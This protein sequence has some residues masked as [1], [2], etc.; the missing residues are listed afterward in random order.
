[1]RAVFREDREID[2]VGSYLPQ[3]GTFVEVGAYH[4]FDH[5]QTWHL[6]QRGWNGALIEPVPEYAERLRQNRS[7]HVFEAACGPPHRHGTQ[8]T[9]YVCGLL[10]SLKHD[11]G[12]SPQIEVRIL[13]LAS[14]LSEA[15]IS[16]LDFLSIDVEGFEIEVLSGFPFDKYRPRLILLEDHA[17]GFTQHRFMQTKGYKRVRRTGYNSWY[18]PN[19]D[20]FEVSIFGRLQIFR[21]YYLAL[22]VRKLKAAIRG[23]GVSTN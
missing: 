5:S 8:D 6:E 15:D 1:M 3:I 20:K 23:H 22:P 16:T 10:S 11:L 17:Y 4:P 12:G 14:I 7:A 13:T 2:L 18:V 21:K 19:E 9:M